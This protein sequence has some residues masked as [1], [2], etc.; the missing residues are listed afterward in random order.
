M[1]SFAQALLVRVLSHI[2]VSTGTGGSS[3]TPDS[4]TPPIPRALPEPAGS[5]LDL[6]ASPR[7][8]LWIG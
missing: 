6:W 2:E 5:I 7:T 1:S 3:A 8:E 4:A